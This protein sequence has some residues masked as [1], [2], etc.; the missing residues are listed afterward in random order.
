MR[1][2]VSAVLV[3][4]ADRS[5]GDCQGQGSSKAKASEW[6]FGCVPLQV[7][8]PK[9]GLFVLIESRHVHLHC[10]SIVHFTSTGC[11]LTCAL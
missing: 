1:G 11:V 9:I 7:I 3:S 4:P 8:P 5:L 10:L 2:V 6:K